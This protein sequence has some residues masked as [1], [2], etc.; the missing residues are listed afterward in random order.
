MRM[1]NVKFKYFY[2][3]HDFYNVRY[4]LSILFITFNI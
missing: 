4:F 2:I 1:H 3:K